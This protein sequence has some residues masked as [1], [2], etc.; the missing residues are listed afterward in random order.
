MGQLGTG[1]N[2]SKITSDMTKNINYNVDRLDFH[3]IYKMVQMPT[4][5][6]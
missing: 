4:F 6:N 2:N 1:I 3:R 5:V